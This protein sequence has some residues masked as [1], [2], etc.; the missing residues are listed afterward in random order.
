HDVHVLA[1]RVEITAVDGD[2]LIEVESYLDSDVANVGVRHWTDINAQCEENILSLEVKTAQSGYKLGM[3]SVL[4]SPSHKS[5]IQTST[6]GAHPT[7]FTA[8]QLQREKSIEFQK[9]TA[10]Y[11]SRDCD[12]PHQAALTKV[13]E[14]AQS[15]YPA[16]FTVH[17]D[18]WAKYWETSDIQIEG[19]EAA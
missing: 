4:L 5:D 11:T 15:G 6:D 2:P 13:R 9:L 18:E 8:V 1:Q 12:N 10:I 14:A 19:D 7:A 17:A 16:L 3:A